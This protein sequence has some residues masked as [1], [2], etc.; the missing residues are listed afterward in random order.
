M[1]RRATITRTVHTAEKNFRE[2]EDGEAQ[3]VGTGLDILVEHGM[4]E[5]VEQHERPLIG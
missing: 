1:G 3:V 4:N 5:E 2:Q